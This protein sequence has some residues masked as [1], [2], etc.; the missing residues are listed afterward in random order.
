[1]PRP[2]LFSAMAVVVEMK[3]PAH[4]WLSLSADA[5]T[6]ALAL[7]GMSAG[8]IA[9]RLYMYNRAQA[10]RVFGDSSPMTL[11]SSHTSS[12][13]R[14]QPD[15]SNRT[16]YARLVRN[17]GC[18]GSDLDRQHSIASNCTSAPLWMLFHWRFRQKWTRR[19]SQM[20]APQGV[21]P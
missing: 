20:F 14:P 12:R 2:S 15:S 4:G 17:L 19:L 11:A 1:V 3:R 13:A 21:S 16:G 7:E 6:Y 5:V 9:V 10:P 8:E 18:Y